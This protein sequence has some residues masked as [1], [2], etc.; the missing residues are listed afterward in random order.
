M[1]ISIYCVLLLTFSYM[2][3]R[4][5]HLQGAY[6]NVVKTYNN[7]AVCNNHAYQMY[8]I[9]LTFADSLISCWLQIVKNV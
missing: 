7:K 4:N 1:H 5:S 2:F 3:W 9:Q 8:R 6:T